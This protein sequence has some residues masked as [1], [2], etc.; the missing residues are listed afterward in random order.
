MRR[1]EEEDGRGWF[2]EYRSRKWEVEVRFPAT[3]GS[4]RGLGVND[5]SACRL[6]TP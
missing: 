5:L 2:L 3:G 4:G 1:T 6:V